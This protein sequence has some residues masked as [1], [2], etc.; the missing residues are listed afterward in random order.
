MSG[1]VGQG[2]EERSLARDEEVGCSCAEGRRLALAKARFRFVSG[3]IQWTTPGAEP[4]SWVGQ[5]QGLPTV[6]GASAWQV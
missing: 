4:P 2:E 3:G 1:D 5:A 6:F